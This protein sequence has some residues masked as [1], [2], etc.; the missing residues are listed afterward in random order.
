[1]IEEFCF[2]IPQ[3]YKTPLGQSMRMVGEGYDHGQVLEMGPQGLFLYGGSFGRP[4]E[5]D[6]G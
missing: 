2:L 4:K 6:L 1:M 5:G 3:N